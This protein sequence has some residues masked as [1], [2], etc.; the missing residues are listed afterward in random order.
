MGLTAE[1]IETA[2]RRAPDGTLAAAFLDEPARSRVLALHLYAGELEHAARAAQ[3]PNLAR[4]RVQW[5]RDAV[6]EVAAGDSARSHPLL[7]ALGDL[8]QARP[9]APGLLD[10]MAVAAMDALDPRPFATVAALDS[11]GDLGAGRLLRACLF[12]AGAPA[13]L[14]A[15]LSAACAAAGQAWALQGLMR[16]FAHWSARRALW[17]P[18]EWMGNTDC[19]TVFAG[20]E[21]A[22]V[23]PLMAMAARTVE[24][25]LRAARAAMSGVRAGP[26]F[27]AIA[28]AS[29]ARPWARR[30]AARSDPWRDTAGLSLLSRQIRLVMT[31]ARGRF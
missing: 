27:A 14:D 7:A 11:W 12:A 25:R 13:P 9:V 10:D 29:L 31:V 28:F 17:A 19:E 21:P 5:W 23:R 6:A 8:M 30:A 15:R 16:D 22:R 2:A 3:D 4:I 26:A 20:A 18:D 24:H 1:Q